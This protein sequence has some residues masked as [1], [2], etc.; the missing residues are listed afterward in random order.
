MADLGTAR[1]RI[2]LEIGDALRNAQQFRDTMRNIDQQ[3]QGGLTGMAE[4]IKRNEAAI[5]SV[6]Q[7]MLGMGIAVTGAFGMGLKS[8]AD[9][10]SGMNRVKALSNA[11]SDQMVMLNDRALELSATT[12]YTATETADAMGF[13]AMAGFDVQQIYDAL[14][15][16]L[17]LAAAAQMDLG[18]A[19][20]LSTNIL[21]AFG[22]EAKDLTYVA[23]MLTYTFTNSNTSM[24]QLGEAF[25]YV[26]PVAQAAG[27]EFHEVAAAL[28]ML[29]DAGIQG[30]MAGTT[31]RGAITRL[32][33][34]TA[35]VK[36]IL[37][38]L[39]ISVTDSNGKMLGLAEIMAQF[40][41]VSQDSAAAMA[42]FQAQAEAA[43]IALEDA[44][45]NARP[46][47]E[48]LQD[49]EA[50]GIDTS[51]ML[52]QLGTDADTVAAIM[53]IFGLRAGP[54]MLALLAMGHEGLSEFANEIA[55]AGGTAERVANTQLEGLKGALLMLRSAWEVLMIRMMDAG[56]IQIVTAAIKALTLGVQQL[57][58]LPAPLL[59]L[60]GILT[61]LTGAVLTLGGAF[62]LLLPRMASTYLALQQFRRWGGMARVFHTVASGI[63]SVS[64]AMAGLAFANPLLLALTA[65]IAAFAAAW[66]FNLFGVRDTIRGVVDSVVTALSR[67]REGFDYFRGLGQ[68]P[69][70]AALNAISAALRAF[71]IGILD[72]IADKLTALGY[73][74]QAFLE[75]FSSQAEKE[76]QKA[77]KH[78]RAWNEEVTDPETGETRWYVNTDD[79]ERAGEI[80]DS[81][82]DEHTG[83]TWVVVRT[84]DG[85]LVTTIDMATGLVEGEYEV[86]IEV[87]TKDARKNIDRLRDGLRSMERQL[88]RQNFDTL[89]DMV[90]YV[91]DAVDNWESLTEQFRQFR[92]IMDPVS[93]GLMSLGAV[94]PQLNGVILPL[95]GYWQ[96]LLAR[97][98]EGVQWFQA[99][100]ELGVNPVSA[101]LLAL[102]QVVPQ[103]SGVLEPLANWVSELAE[104]FD[105]WRDRFD[106]LRD[107]M[108]PVSAALTALG[109]VVAP[110]QPM[111]TELVEVVG[112]L[113]GAW[114]SLMEGDFTGFL[115]GVESALGNLWDA[116]VEGVE[117]L[118]TRAVPGIIDAFS[119]ILEAAN[120][121]D[122]AGVAS[123]IREWAD[124]LATIPLIGWLVAGVLDGI[125]LAINVIGIVISVAQS[126]WEG[127]VS[128]LEQLGLKASD[129][130]TELG[131]LSTKVSDAST[132]VGN[133]KT[134]FDE[135]KEAIDSLPPIVKEI[136]RA[137]VGAWTALAILTATLNLALAPFRSLAA[138]LGRMAGPLITIGGALT[139]LHPA[140]AVI[141]LAIASGLLTWRALE[142]NWM[143]LRDKS[144]PLWDALQRVADGLSMVWRVVRL[145]SRDEWAKIQEGM[146]AVELA[147]SVLDEVLGDLIGDL[148][149]LGIIVGIVA[150]AAWDTIVD[151]AQKLAIAFD[152]LAG[153]VDDLLNDLAQLALTV[154]VL[155]MA[156]W[157]KIESGIEKVGNAFEWAKEKI[158]PL[159]DLVNSLIDALEKLSNLKAP[160]SSDD[161]GPEFSGG[162]QTGEGTSSGARG[163]GGGGEAR[164]ETESQIRYAAAITNTATAL[165]VL[166]EVLAGARTEAE[167]TA[168][169]FSIIG[170]AADTTALR[171]QFFARNVAEP[172]QALPWMAQ[173]SMLGVRL[174]MD[175]G[176]AAVGTGLTTAGASWGAIMQANTQNLGMIAG[177]GFGQIPAQAIPPLAQTG[178]A[179][180]TQTAAMLTA[181][182][183]N[184]SQMV[185]R[186]AATFPVINTTGTNNIR[187][188]GSSVVASI[189]STAG[190]F[191][192]NLANMASN[193]A[194]QFSSIRTTGTDET[195]SMRGNVVREVTD[196]S[197]MSATEVA[198]MQA[199]IAMSMLVMKQNV[200]SS[201]S[202]AR[203]S[204]VREFTDMAT[205]AA[206][207][208]STGMNAIPGIIADA[209]SRAASTAR[210]VG[211][212]IGA[213]LAAGMNSML[214]QV[215]A[216][217]NALVNEAA[218]AMAAAA[219]VRSP[220][221]VTQYIGQMMGMG[222]V[223]GILEKIREATRAAQTYMGALIGTFQSYDAPGVGV[224]LD[225]ANV[226][227]LASVASPAL[228]GG[229]TM[230][231]N[232]WNIT[233]RPGEDGV[234]FAERVAEVFRNDF[235]AT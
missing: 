142:E 124:E 129:A 34:P 42:E 115:G 163:F 66:T 26:G 177:T 227:R 138:L 133:A 78:F 180:A 40:P 134:K 30:S 139:R 114:D 81:W 52:E 235:A 69:V 146:A 155:A 151:W 50:A 19:A 14:P 126:I 140:F 222:T 94:F 1:A 101:A 54:G 67:L 99:F 128:I 199:G 159:L 183:S 171:I 130:E 92:Q 51:A 82:T 38:D 71:D 200:T 23:D 95:V 105:E 3:A 12:R 28:G 188:M 58:K 190:S 181:A 145:L 230:I 22:M 110:L 224:G 162:T 5:N 226:S 37:D 56:P 108:D 233:Q 213:G 135:L 122:W 55:N 229:Q 20:D 116:F 203:G 90:G 117:L 119:A 212:A 64:L 154:G 49:M 195:A 16:T 166:R 96:Q 220:S 187:S 57:L 100:R 21:T 44:E 103:L 179:V 39:G 234:A 120:N 2:I 182:G 102:S 73:G 13:L 10:E 194:R 86:E 158:Q 112:D 127:F 89:A 191:A 161:D 185:S 91:A 63:R 189:G 47:Q 131:D 168:S 9:F 32:I 207:A 221:R 77:T 214:G 216:A 6:G 148:V 87:E 80:I 186:A 121:I 143:G 59:G 202:E 184:W 76:V 106:E 147:A 205:R 196:M 209:G 228:R 211:V 33:S 53:E 160:W 149:Q 198:G 206:Q 41:P 84:E 193:A 132:E 218:R 231:V 60:I 150:Q 83:E 201:A 125:A 17:N 61:G 24:E 11:T 153:A 70:S 113:K 62:L 232:E 72:T 74:I 79:G 192:S 98:Q 204:V 223:V 144:E 35:K 178:A 107:S 176:L 217:A 43:G 46:F 170:E 165:L 172:F 137:F 111:M 219:I 152:L 169:S 4:G 75:G 109:D 210:M 7:T 123:R 29:G 197:S 27:L 167:A 175:S 85:E 8:A 173:D 141:T 208:V 118:W 174:A 25:K 104:K 157:D 225:L 93:A 45:G 15:G 36:G 31:L 18:R 136:G 88:R 156:A 97:V 215:R 65:A 164:E 48:V 68:N